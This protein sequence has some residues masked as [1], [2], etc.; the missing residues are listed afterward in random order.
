MYLALMRKL[1]KAGNPDAEGPGPPT[2]W[3]EGFFLQSPELEVILCPGKLV[4]A[5]SEHLSISPLSFLG[6]AAGY[7]ETR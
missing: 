7:L 3:L 2:S 1:C 5:Q 6:G 4:W